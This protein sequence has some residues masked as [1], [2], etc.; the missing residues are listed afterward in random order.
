MRFIGIDVHRDFCE[1]AIWED[2]KLRRH[3]RVPARRPALTSYA[4][5][6][7]P[8]DQVG[9]EATGNAL[10]DRPNHRTPRGQGRHRQWRRPQGD[11]RR[12]GQDGPPRR[13]HA[14][15]ASRIRV[16]PADL[17]LVTIRPASLGAACRDGPSS[18]VNEL[19]SA[20]RSMP[21]CT[22]ISWTARLRQIS[23]G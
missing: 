18:F 22:A 4:R 8:T 13:P 17:G 2:G 12:Q 7:Q 19:L 10:S 23:L 3:P 14:R 15:P 21:S 20:T 6:L 5:S 9:L 1:I 11:R 16:L